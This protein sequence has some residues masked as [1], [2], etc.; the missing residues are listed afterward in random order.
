MENIYHNILSFNGEWRSYQKKV[1]LDRTAHLSDKKIHIVAAPGSGKTT[2]GIELIKRLGKPCLILSPSIAIKH[3]WLNRIQDSF[4]SENVLAS[5]WLSDDLTKPSKINSITYQALHS[6]TLQFVGTL[7]DEELSLQEQVDFKHFDLYNTLEQAGIETICLDEAHHLR[8]EWWKALEMLL[9]KMPNVTLISLTA[10]PPYDV[11]AD[12]WQRYIS[13][14]GPIDAEI[15]VPELVKEK[16]LCPHQDYLYFNFPTSEETIAINEYQ[17][18]VQTCVKQLLQDKRFIQILTSHKGL[19]NPEQYTDEL[20]EKPQYLVSILVALQHFAIPIPDYFKKLFHIKKT[21]PTINEKWLEI[22]LQ[23]ML[24]DDVEAYTWNENE[25][26]VFIDLCKSYGCITRN[27]VNLTVNK[28]VSKILISSKGKLNAISDITEKEYLSLG[29]K[30]RQLILCDYIKKEQ[31]IHIGDSKKEIN[32][33]GAVPIFELL[34]RK[35][36]PGIKLG[37]LSGSVIILPNTAI[38]KFMDLLREHQAQANILELEETA[39]SQIIWKDKKNKIVPIIT[40]LFQIGDINVLIGT[41][42]LLGE[43]WDAPHIN[44]LIM[45]SFIGSYMLSNQMRGRAIRAFPSNPEKVSNIWHLVCIP[46]PPPLFKKNNETAEDTVSQE[47]TDFLLMERRFEMF[48]GLHY[49]ED[50]IENGIDR[51]TAI[52]KPFSKRNVAHINEKMLAAAENRENVKNRWQHA[53]EV[54]TD[55]FSTEET[56]D[57]DKKQPH[58]N[59]LFINALTAF[60]TFFLLTALLSLTRLSLT[61]TRIIQ[62]NDQLFPQH[63]KL[64]AACL[65]LFLAISVFLTAKYGLQF[66][67]LFTPQKRLKKIS[68]AVVSVL[69]DAAHIQSSSVKAKVEKVNE[70]TV[71]TCLKG[72]SVREKTLFA[73]CMKEFLGP[74]ENPRYLLVKQTRNKLT[75]DYFAVPELF[76]K[77]KEDALLFNQAINQFVGKYRLVYTRTPEGRKC[78]LKARIQSFSAINHQ[79]LTGK[80][81]VKGN[82][83]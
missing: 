2:L 69:Q 28:E 11:S 73:L 56:I 50:T 77:N 82:F 71:S 10:T 65:T 75:M 9:K 40:T 43:G 3:Q 76:G 23:G 46:P 55:D 32:D 66:F 33:I 67:N 18:K 58:L 36:L 1:L 47:S 51:I 48:L 29:N 17:G 24:Y 21:F 20:L 53:L 45:A 27:K 31:L 54:I 64:F 80:K 5:D 16:S 35:E 6:S 26:Q 59:Y 52:E 37:V 63:I 7:D 61:A 81:R 83:D 70:A 78:L 13:L 15:S 60:I 72:G 42:S 12:Q 41:K 25:H 34:R 49:S 4:L 79:Y 8:S 39:Y 62:T 22:L 44:T 30:L 68:Q 14:C 74:I 57:I 38:N 19:A